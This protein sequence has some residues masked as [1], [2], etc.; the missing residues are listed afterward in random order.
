MY[1]SMQDC[2]A[3]ARWL[4]ILKSHPNSIIAKYQT[5][6]HGGIVLSLSFYLAQLIDP[7]G[8]PQIHSPACKEEL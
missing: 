1:L 2:R 8:I 7:S 5:A 3:P 4:K 6:K